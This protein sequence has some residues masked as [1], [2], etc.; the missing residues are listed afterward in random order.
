[1]LSAVMSAAM[2][3]HTAITAMSIHQFTDTV[4]WWV[5]LR[6]KTDA[7][8]GHEA[9]T[10]IS[11]AADAATGSSWSSTRSLRDSAE[12]E[13]STGKRASADAVA[14]I[15]GWCG[16]PPPDQGRLQS[17]RGAAVSTRRS[18]SFCF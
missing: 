10:R 3:Q 13:S 2:K 5:E 17:K 9:S 6:A 1:M 7:T 18:L 12:S 16:A 14:G 11:G 8:A 4:E 15:G